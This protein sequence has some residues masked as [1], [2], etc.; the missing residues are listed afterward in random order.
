M[1]TDKARSSTGWRRLLHALIAALGIVTIVGS[2]GGAFLPDIDIS[3]PFDLPPSASITPSRATVQVGATV[4]FTVSTVF[5]KQPFSYQWRRNGV[6]IIGA[7]GTSYMLAG[8][9]LGDDGALFEVTVTASNGVTTAGALLRVSS[10][11]GVVYQDGDFA[12][13]GWFVTAIVEPLQNAPTHT[14]SRQATGGN[15]DAF[16]GI[17]YQMPQGPSSARLFHAAQNATYDPAL[18]GAIYTIDLALDCN[19]LS[20]STTSETLA[21]PTFAQGGRRFAPQQWD[22]GCA[23][24]WQVRYLSSLLAN[25]FVLV[26]GPPCTAGEACPDFSANAAPLRFGFV[27]GVILSSDAGAGAITQGIDN[28]KVTVWRR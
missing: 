24:L 9:N 14:E 16:R 2:G 13:S 22:T 8:A 17:A 18:Q 11:P 27:S 26:E 6:D 20:T 12:A 7:T 21:L 15:P 25:E 5:G 23:P 10:A 28:W 3:G 19:R 1:R 4:S